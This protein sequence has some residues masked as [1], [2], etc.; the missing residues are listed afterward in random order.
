MREKLQSMGGIREE[1]TGIFVRFGIKTAW[2]GMQKTVLLSDIKNKH[3]KVVVDHL[4]FN[5][6]AGFSKINLQEGDEVSFRGRVKQ[7]LKGYAGHREEIQW[8]KPI[9]KDYKL[10][11]PTNIRLIKRKNDQQIHL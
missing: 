3:G 10:S 1:F 2:I 4:W 8:E 6:T 7:Y 9:E 11:H 5:M